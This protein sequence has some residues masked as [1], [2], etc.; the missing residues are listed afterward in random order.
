MTLDAKRDLCGCFRVRMVDGLE[1]EIKVSGAQHD[2]ASVYEL[3]ARDET[4]WRWIGEHAWTVVQRWIGTHDVRC[5]HCGATWRDNHPDA[6]DAL[7]WCGE[8]DRSVAAV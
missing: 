2:F 3:D 5:A 1:H 6:P 8:C 4:G 7:I